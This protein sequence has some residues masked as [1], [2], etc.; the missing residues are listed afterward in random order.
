MRVFCAVHGIIELGECAAHVAQTP[1]FYRLDGVRQLGGC[2]YVYPSATHTRREHSLGVAWLSRKAGQRLRQ[3]HPDLVSV[4][5]VARLELAGLVH[6]LGHG[7]FSHMFETCVPTFSHEAEG[8]RILRALA[9]DD[10]FAALAARVLGD[11]WLAD[12]ERMV[13]GHDGHDPARAFL[14][15]IVHAHR[16]GIDTDKLDYLERDCLAVMGTSNVLSA[17]RIVDGMRIV[18]EDHGARTLGFDERVEAEVCNVYR[19]RAMMHRQVYQHRSVLLVESLLIDMLHRVDVARAAEGAPLLLAQ[20]VEALVDASFLLHPAARAREVMAWKEWRRLPTVVHVPTSPRCPRCGA[21]THIAHR[22][23]TQCGSALD[24]RAFVLDAHGVR[25]VAEADVT[26]RDV[27]RAVQQRCGAAA[28]VVISDIRGGTHLLRRDVQGHAWNDWGWDT[29]PIV[30]TTS[31][32]PDAPRTLPTFARWREA[33][34][35]A[36]P[37]TSDDEAIRIDAAF[38]GWATETF[39]GLTPKK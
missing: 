24:E 34:C 33:V 10:A 9:D 38:A 37:G 4:S 7:P 20:R 36:P 23:C 39:P 19:I 25:S 31:R 32:A 21:E 27:T 5:D 2:S 13:L 35:Y 14:F 1:A 30:R 8:M 3:L 22:H 26:A 6:D 11:G 16:S 28:R 17:D 29:I 18:F 12:V 15:Q